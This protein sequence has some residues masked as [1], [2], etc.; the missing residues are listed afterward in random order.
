MVTSLVCRRFGFRI[1]LSGRAAGCR[2]RYICACMPI[3]TIKSYL[4]WLSLSIFFISRTLEKGS[5]EDPPGT[6]FWGKRGTM[7]LAKHLQIG[8]GRTQ[9][10]DNQ[11]IQTR[12]PKKDMAIDK[13]GPWSRR[14]RKPCRLGPLGHDCLVQSEPRC[15]SLPKILSSANN[16]CLDRAVERVSRTSRLIPL[17]FASRKY[18]RGRKT[19]KNGRNSGTQ[20]AML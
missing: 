15:S 2:L 14:N 9:T 8:F 10:E 17:L 6:G 18:R 13:V 16:F 20:R 5:R 4:I 7:L 3:Y 11:S 19:Q 1:I 12:K